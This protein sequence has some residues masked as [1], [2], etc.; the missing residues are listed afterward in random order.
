MAKG[1]FTLREN[2]HRKDSAFDD[3]GNARLSL[4]HPESQ[5]DQARVVYDS[6]R[7]IFTLETL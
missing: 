4:G 2:Y 1:A 5:A 3:A 6:A 7:Q